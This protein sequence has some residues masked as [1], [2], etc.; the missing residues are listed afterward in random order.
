MTYHV[1]PRGNWRQFLLA[2]DQERSVDLKLLRKCV[3]L[4]RLSPPGYSLMSNHV[5]LVMAPRDG[6]PL[7]QA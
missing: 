4:L 1:T 6:E 7:A 3:D 5:H 2:I